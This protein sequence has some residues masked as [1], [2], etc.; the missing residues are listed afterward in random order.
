VIEKLEKGVSVSSI[1]AEYGIAKQSVSDIKKAK[2]DIRN[3]VLKFN[4]EKEK[5]EVKRMWI[6]TLITLD[7]AVYKWFVINRTFIKTDNL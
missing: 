5:S 1:C 4:V 3:F 6:P 2:S 7:G